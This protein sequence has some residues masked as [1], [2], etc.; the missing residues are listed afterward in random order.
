MARVMCVGTATLDIVNRVEHY[1]LED[2]EIRALSQTRR[3]GGNAANSAIV[4]A[5]LGAEATWTGHLAQPADR[6]ERTLRGY[7]V[8]TS[9]ATRVPGATTPTSYILLSEATGS[10][11]IVH[12]RD[13]PEYPADAFLGLDLRRFDWVHF[14]GRAIDQLATMLSHARRQC[15]LPVSL[16][17]EK[18]RSGIEDLFDQADLLLFSRDYAEARGVTHPEDLLRGLR[19]GVLATCTWGADGAWA[20]DQDG[21]LWHSPAPALPSVIDTIGAGD[22]FNAAM[23]HAVTT[24]KTVEAALP[25]AVDLASRQCTREGL[26]LVDD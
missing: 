18:P 26:D 15:G 13:L 23:I 2:S 21:R 11:S 3:V 4:L 6:I 19:K 7:G 25:F 16:E 14:E 5:Q 8:D 24:G 20:I 12:Y 1:P 10:R 22:V 9:L 17:I